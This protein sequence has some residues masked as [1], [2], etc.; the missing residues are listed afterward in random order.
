MYKFP[1]NYLPYFIGLLIFYAL[2]RITEFLD[3]QIYDT[4]QFISGH[5][6]KHLFAAAA[7]CCILIM[8][9]KRKYLQS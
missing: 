5:T 9:K 3:Q 7:A 6:L 8:L 2:S 1:E 4:L